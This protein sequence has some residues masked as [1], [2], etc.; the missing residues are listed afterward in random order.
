M[1]WVADAVDRANDEL[2]NNHMAIGPSHFLRSDLTEDWVELI[3]AHSILPY[4]AE[5][6]FGDDAR[7]E[8]F[9]L[10][11]LRQPRLPTFEPA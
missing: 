5:Q 4:I 8:A 9:A 11:K 1:L 10:A 3:W 2:G 7:L 6:Y